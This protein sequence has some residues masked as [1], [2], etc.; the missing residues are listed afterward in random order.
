MFVLNYMNKMADEN[1][2]LRSTD[3]STKMNSADET[4]DRK[5][6]F[7]INFF[8]VYKKRKKGQKIEVSKLFY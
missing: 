7:Y 8:A 2:Y 1:I 6:F 5:L 3:F 4:R